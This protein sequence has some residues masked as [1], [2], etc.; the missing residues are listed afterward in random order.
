[1]QR[2]WKERIQLIYYKHLLFRDG[3]AEADH[4][5]VDSLETL[6]PKPPVLLPH[7]HTLQGKAPVSTTEVP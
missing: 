7:L 6:Q 2:R 1:M 5:W 4:H 3:F